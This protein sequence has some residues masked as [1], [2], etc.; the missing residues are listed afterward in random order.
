[1]RIL[2]NVMAESVPFSLSDV[3]LAEKIFPD[4]RQCDRLQFDQICL[5]R[6][7]SEES[8]RLG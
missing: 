3:M 4:M 6:P 8:G 1:M 5:A 2:V 7:L